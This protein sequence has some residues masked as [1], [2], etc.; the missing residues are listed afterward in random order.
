M[1]KGARCMAEHAESKEER[2]AVILKVEGDDA[3][4]FF[5]ELEPKLGALPGG[6]DEESRKKWL[7]EQKKAAQSALPLIGKKNTEC[8][9][10]ADTLKECPYP[11]EAK[12]KGCAETKIEAVD[13]FCMPAGEII[14]TFGAINNAVYTAWKKTDDFER[15]WFIPFPQALKL[16]CDAC[17]D[18]KAL[19]ES[20]KTMG[21]SFEAAVAQVAAEVLKACFEAIEKLPG[22]IESLVKAVEGFQE[23]IKVEEGQ[24]PTDKMKALAEESGL[25]GLDAVKAVKNLGSNAAVLAAAPGNLSALLVSCKFVVSVCTN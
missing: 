21:A 23:L 25:A 15:K 19:I 8:V 4:I 3:T 9:V 1:K 10:K 7:E 5:P 20:A 6:T 24:S 18:P 17:S 11:K 2:I 22:L 13:G 14:A 12:A 16:L